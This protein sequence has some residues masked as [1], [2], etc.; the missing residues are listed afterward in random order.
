MVFIVVALFAWASPQVPARAQT[1]TQE[2]SQYMR[3]LSKQVLAV[4]V[5]RNSTLNE[6]EA[7]VR[8]ILGKNFELNI[9]GRYV[10]GTA[11]R[12]ATS[13][14]KEQYQDLFK[15]WVLRTYARRLGGYTGQTFD[16]LGAKPLG[17]KDALVSTR[18]SRPSGPPIMAG[19]R[20]R[21]IGGE[22]KILDVMVQ[23][24]SM[25]VTQRSEFRAVVRRQGVDGLIEVLRLQ[26]TKF[27]ARGK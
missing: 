8:A 23:G 5:D 12:G 15:Q 16:I 18:I 14:Q 26:V 27:A 25:V 19:W 13:D 20:V 1:P 3:G 11:W 6:R 4:L 17:K 22:F 9:I 2:A 24:V 21:K 10:L 7:N